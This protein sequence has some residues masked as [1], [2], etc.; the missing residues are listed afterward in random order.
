ME[1]V[2]GP[3][4]GAA[5]NLWNTTQAAAKPEVDMTMRDVNNLRSFIPLQNIPYFDPLFD[6]LSNLAA[7]A[8]GVKG[9]RN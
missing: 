8:I 1:A 2:F 5:L 7:D 6:A 4:Y 3:T 9:K